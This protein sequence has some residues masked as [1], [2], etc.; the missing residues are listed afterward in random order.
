MRSL[1]REAA[2][3]RRVLREAEQ[4]E[5][6]LGAFEERAEAGRLLHHVSLITPRLFKR[7]RRMRQ[8]ATNLMKQ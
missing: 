7:I 6:G 1:L 3:A 5:E 4:A 8:G 2:T